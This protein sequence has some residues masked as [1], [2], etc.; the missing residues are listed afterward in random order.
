MNVLRMFTVRVSHGETEYPSPVSPLVRQSNVGK[1][2]EN[3]VYRHAVNRLPILGEHGFDF[4]MIQGGRCF[5]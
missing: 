2:V 1:P 5:L 3:P 4:G